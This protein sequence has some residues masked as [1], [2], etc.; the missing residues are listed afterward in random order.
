[1]TA[2]Q[3]LGSVDELTDGTGRL[4]GRRHGGEK[5][6]MSEIPAKGIRHRPIVSDP[7]LRRR[8]G[9]QPIAW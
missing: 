8:G 7:A 2:V 6:T 5:R 9:F 1:M 4:G 3:V